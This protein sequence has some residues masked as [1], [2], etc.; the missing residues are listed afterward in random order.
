MSCFRTQRS[1]SSEARTPQSLDLESSKRA[2]RTIEL[3]PLTSWQE[4][5]E[6]CYV[7]TGVHMNYQPHRYKITTHLSRYSSV[8][9]TGIL[10][11]VSFIPKIVFISTKCTIYSLILRY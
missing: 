4:K 10:H 9:N 7:G 5:L 8:T 6:L 2:P 3:D 1:S 11:P